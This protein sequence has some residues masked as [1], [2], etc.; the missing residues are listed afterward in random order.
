SDGTVIFSLKRIITDGS[1][2]MFELCKEQGKPVLHFYPKL[3]TDVLGKQ[4]REFV[5]VEDISVLNVDGPRVSHEPVIGVFLKQCLGNDRTP[6]GRRAR[7]ERAGDPHS[8]R[9]S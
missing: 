4:L 3:G 6:L 2:P 5:Q 7:R 1:L 9:A 8:R